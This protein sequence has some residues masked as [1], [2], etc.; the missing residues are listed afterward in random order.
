MKKV[1][2]IDDEEELCLLLKLYLSRKN[3]DTYIS[4]SL[5]EGKVKFMSVLP[6]ILFI[7]NNLPDGTG[8]DYAMTKLLPIHNTHLFF[9]SAY[10]PNLPQVPAGIKYTVLEK[11]ISFSD[12][13]KKLSEV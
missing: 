6:D 5:E 9:I 12:L 3:Y 11:P 2:I 8:W 10:H 13:D 1:L 7:D 4:H